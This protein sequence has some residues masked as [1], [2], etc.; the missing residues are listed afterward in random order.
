MGKL[1]VRGERVWIES[2]S[3]GVTQAAEMQNRSL[4]V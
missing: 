1:C 3:R 4:Q 2:I